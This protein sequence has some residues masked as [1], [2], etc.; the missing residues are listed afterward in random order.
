MDRCPAGSCEE[1]LPEPSRRTRF[2]CGVGVGE[3][4]VPCHLAFVCGDSVPPH[5]ASPH[6][7]L[8]CPD[9]TRAGFGY[10]LLGFLLQ[11]RPPFR[12]SH[13]RLALVLRSPWQQL[14]L[15]SSLCCSLAP[16]FLI[17]IKKQ[18]TFL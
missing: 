12:R 7:C 4:S 10:L 6:S 11:E 14:F 3:T 5:T 9:G 8:G 15:G 1:P 16:T 18:L 17:V 13:L 2:R